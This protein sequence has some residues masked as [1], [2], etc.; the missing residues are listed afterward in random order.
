LYY[1]ALI[2]QIGVGNVDLINT[3]LSGT[4]VQNELDFGLW[5]KD[6][7]DQER[8]H[9]GM[10]LSVDAGNFVF[11]LKEDGLMLNYDTWDVNPENF[12]AF[13]HQGILAHQFDLSQNGQSLSARSQDS[14]GNSPL[15]LVFS[16][17]RI[18][19]FSKLLESEVL[20]M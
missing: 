18:E 1:S 11:H 17:F 3:L 15:D 14:L 5:I 12:I 6:E 10:E 20:N 7:K 8:Y 13:G 4:V 19:T 16:N 2:K 9:L